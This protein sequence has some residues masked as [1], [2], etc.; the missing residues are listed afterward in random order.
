MNNTEASALDRFRTALGRITK[1]VKGVAVVFAKVTLA[2]AAA[3][4]ALTAAAAVAHADTNDPSV[5]VV[6]N[7]DDWGTHAVDNDPV[8]Y[9]FPGVEACPGDAAYVSYEPVAVVDGTPVWDN[10]CHYGS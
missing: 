1:A 3:A 5:I 9:T 6:D 2:V 10:V 4:T 7:N 8:T